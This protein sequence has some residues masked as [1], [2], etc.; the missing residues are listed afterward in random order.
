MITIPTDERTITDQQVFDALNPDY[1]G[2]E[3]VKS[4]LE[5]GNIP[6]AKKQLVRH[7]E[8]RNHPHFLY[9]YRALPLSPID[10]DS[11]PY[12]FQAS[13]GLS[14]SL[15]EFCLFAGR[16]MMD[17]VYVLPG[18]G[19]R[20]VDLGRNWEH[21]IHFNFIEDMGKK[22]RNPLD[23]IVR[24]QFFEYLA[25]L[26]H[27]TGDPKVLDSF[28]EV[29][30]VFFQT[31]PLQVVNGSPSTDRFQYTEDRDVMSA[32]WLSVVYTGLFYTRVPYEISTDLAFEILK[33]IWFLGIQFRRFDEDGYRPYNH[34]MWE[35]GLVPFILGTMF[36]EI[37]AFTAMKEKGAK[38]VC[39]HI[40]EDFNPSGGY[41]EHSIAYW[42]GAAV[43]E[44]LYRGIYLARLNEEPFLDEETKHRMEQTFHVLALI[45][46][47]GS[48]Y[49]SL[50]D[51]GGPMLEPI[52]NLGVRMM[53]HEDCAHVLAARHGDEHAAERLPLD[54]CCD[55]AGFV[56]ARSGY[57]S[58][59]N[60]MLMSAKV[61]CGY[62]GHNHMDMLSLFLTFHG[63]EIIGEP[64][65]DHMYHRVRMNSE[66]R[67]YMYNM[68]S[69]NTVLA[70]GTPILPNRMYANKWGVLRTPSPITDTYSAKDGFYVNA[71]HDGYTFCRHQREVLFHRERGVII[72]D[73]ILRGNRIE[74]DH[75]QRWNMMPGTQVTILNN[76]A[77]LVEKNGVKLLFLWT[78]AE[79]QLSLSKA[80]LLSP[81]MIPS[82]EDLADIIDVAFHAREDQKNQN[83][84]VTL[85]LMILD[86]TGSPTEHSNIT[87]EQLN[88]LKEEASAVCG[89]LN[90][91]ETLERF[92]IY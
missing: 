85:N 3:A 44:M 91:P 82:R 63:E 26:Y 24:G 62:C 73:H 25:V 69:H 74:G 22:H 88:R 67:G 50:G 29:L 41:S 75:I 35:R 10:T 92:P 58:D 12:S 43:G 21:M 15:K 14:E 76:D 42:S 86:L 34:H 39:R 70:Y 52:L 20:E 64:Y 4:A 68:A 2:L 47:P 31:Y 8:T 30:Q 1:P 40:A 57:G 36:P 48:R 46:P 33:R 72:S 80:D 16:K 38:T 66:I 90:C 45:S 77:A 55:Q 7:M 84:T 87:A 79:H 83:V 23:M 18:A 71:Y 19:R 81:E 37:P 32:G 11:C 89:Q 6:E 65:V 13:L 56:S 17:H 49:P 9:D 59:A 60:Y 28:E 54:Y 53:E 78:G 5:A 51:N 27:E 61:N